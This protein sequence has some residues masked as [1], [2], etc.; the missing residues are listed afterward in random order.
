MYR[1]Y[2][3]FDEICLFEDVLVFSLIFQGGVTVDRLVDLVLRN[4]NSRVS[5]YIVHSRLLKH[6]CNVF[7]AEATDFSVVLLRGEIV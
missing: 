4:W 7:L 1:N 5:Q 3:V 6:R 2:L